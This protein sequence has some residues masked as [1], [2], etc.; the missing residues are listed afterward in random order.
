MDE[1]VIRK[2]F[3][4]WIRLGELYRKKEILYNNL[5]GTLAA[6][7]A[8]VRELYKRLRNHDD[9]DGDND[10]DVAPRPPFAR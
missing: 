7:E 9:D 1:F 10:N 8:E 3:Y 4:T 2:Q 6:S 5:L